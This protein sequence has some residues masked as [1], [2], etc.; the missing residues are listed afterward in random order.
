MAPWS[1]GIYLLRGMMWLFSGIAIVVF[2]S[3]MAAYS[4]Q[5]PGMES[6][7]H[8][9]QDLKILG[10]TDE[11]IR[12]AEKEPFHGLPEGVAFLGL[13]PI[14]IGIAYLIYYKVEGKN[15]GAAAPS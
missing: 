11:E 6:R 7:L 9:A 4:R 14:G 10:A 8:R 2:L 12:E 1:G 5:N 3:V 13:V 15:S